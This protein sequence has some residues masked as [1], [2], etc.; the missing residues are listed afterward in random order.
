MMGWSVGRTILSM[1]SLKQQ[2]KGAVKSEMVNECSCIYGV[3]VKMILR[4]SQPI[5]MK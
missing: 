5:I 4:F 3:N 2:E 1:S